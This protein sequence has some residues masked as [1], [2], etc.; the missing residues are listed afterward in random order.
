M[1]IR[2]AEPRSAE[3]GDPGPVV[4]DLGLDRDAIWAC[5]RVVRRT[6]EALCAPLETEDY[7]VQSM[8]DASP[9]KWHLAHTS[10]FFETFVLAP[11]NAG[12]SARRSSI[13]LPLQFLLQ[14][15]G[16]ADRARSARPALAADGGR[17]L[18]LPRGDRRQDGRVPRAGRRGRAR[19]GP[20]HAHPRAAPRA[21]APGADPHRPQ[22]RPRPAIRCARSI[23]SDEQRRRTRQPGPGRRAGFRF[24]RPSDRSAMRAMA[25]RSTTRRRGTAEYVDA[26]A[27]ADRLVTNR[28]YLAF[29]D[30]G[31]Y[32]RPELWL[33]DGWAACSRNGWDGPPLLGGRRRAMACLHA[34]RDARPRSRRAGLPRQLLRGRRLRPLGRRPA[35]HRGRVGNRGRRRWAAIDG[36]FLESG[37]LHPAPCL[38]T[39]ADS[40]RRDA[41]PALRRRLGVD[42]EPLH[43]LPR[44]PPGRRS[45]RANTTASS[46]A[47]RWSSAAARAPRPGRTSGRPTATSSRPRRA[48][49]SR[50]SGWPATYDRDSMMLSRSLGLRRSIAG[51]AS[52]GRSSRAPFLSRPRAA[53]PISFE[54]P[55]HRFLNGGNRF[56]GG[57]AP[58]MRL[59]SSAAALSITAAPASANWPW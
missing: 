40:P 20:E 53:R 11:E 12:A 38:T 13:F 4:S 18:R 1:S 41:R 22:A 7:V 27:L 21:A 26:F 17:G 55:R 23:A 14:R 3:L 49:S 31:G 34:R 42:A 25:S 24:P 52:G 15:R 46:C 50:E 10:W 37:R 6:T 48:G 9:A 54:I 45:A 5:Y 32:G 35:C 29:I 43:A 57:H 47:T 8:P 16:R 33:S 59:A 56:G 58:K 19:P 51:I 39:A 28:E 2:L 36:N 30:D 44:L